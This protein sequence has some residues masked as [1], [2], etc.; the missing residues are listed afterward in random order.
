MRK[1]KPFHNGAAIGFAKILQ[2]LRIFG[3]KRCR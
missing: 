3:G 1:F 2:A